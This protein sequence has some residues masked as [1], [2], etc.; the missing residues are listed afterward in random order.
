MLRHP[1]QVLNLP[2]LQPRAYPL[3]TS[4]F[5][6]STRASKNSFATISAFTASRA[7]LARAVILA[8]ETLIG[9]SKP[10]TAASI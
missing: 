3:D 6:C 4:A 5:S 8:D 2:W 10:P 1:V 7:V 9:P